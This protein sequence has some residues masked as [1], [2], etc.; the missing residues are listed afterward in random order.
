MLHPLATLILA[1]QGVPRLENPKFFWLPDTP[2]ESKFPFWP[3]YTL[4]NV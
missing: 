4:I 3:T 1:W 2:A